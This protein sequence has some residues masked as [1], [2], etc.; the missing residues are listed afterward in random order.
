MI[1]QFRI[2]KS[3]PAKITVN[4]MAIEKVSSILVLILMTE[5]CREYLPVKQHLGYLYVRPV[6]FNE[7]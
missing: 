2:L 5:T 7:S 4:G 3:L 1:I 6:T